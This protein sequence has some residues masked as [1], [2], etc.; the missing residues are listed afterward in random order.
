M[1]WLAWETSMGSPERMISLPRATRVTA[2]E[3]RNNF[4]VWSLSPNN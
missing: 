4:K 3:S 2:K 1:T